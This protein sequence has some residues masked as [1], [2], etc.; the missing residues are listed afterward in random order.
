MINTATCDVSLKLLTSYSHVLNPLSLGWC[1]D[2]MCVHI[3]KGLLLCREGV[4]GVQHLKV[5]A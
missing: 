4:K 2:L 5:A 1:K 3:E